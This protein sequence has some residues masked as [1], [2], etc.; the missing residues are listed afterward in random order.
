MLH[1]I[2]FIGWLFAPCYAVIAATLSLDPKKQI[3]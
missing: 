2:P 1:F 3:D